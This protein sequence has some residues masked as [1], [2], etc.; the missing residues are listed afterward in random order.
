LTPDCPDVHPERE[1]AL[2]VRLLIAIC[3]GY[4]VAQLAL[5]P[6]HRPP[7]WDE[8]IYLSQVTPGVKAVFFMAHRAR[9]ITLLV[10]PVTWLGGSVAAVRLYLVVVSTL[11][12]A[13]VFWL[14][15]P[16]V[17]MAV[18]IAAFSF[19]FS[20][21]ALLSGSEVMPNFWA[22]ILGLGVAG[23]MARRFQGGRMRSVVFAA[24][25]LG[26]VALFRPT[27]SAVITA[28]VGAFVLIRRRASWRDLA[29][30]GVGLILGW[31]PWL[32]EMSIR[33]GGPLSAFREAGSTHVGGASLAQHVHAHLAFTTGGSPSSPIPLAGLA[34][35]GVLV[36]MAIVAVARGRNPSDRIA[37]LLCFI[38]AVALAVEYLAFVHPV[39]PRFLLP[40]YA[41][42]SIPL[43]VGTMS[44]L[45]DRIALRA[46]GSVVLV[47]LLPWAV[48]QGA[49]GER[50][51]VPKTNALAAFQDVGSTLRR[52]AAGRPCSFISAHWYPELQLASGCVGSSLRRSSGPSTAQLSQLEGRGGVVFVVMSKQA[53]ASSPL[54]SLAPTR[55][56]ARP[57]FV[58]EIPE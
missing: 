48:W 20:W 22:A 7:G 51:Q 31:L 56:G 45:R 30:L 3:L 11:A 43:G 36:A 53:P 4:A 33:F 40:T 41:F 24:A 25:L 23:F 26:G 15:I 47:L 29:V 12:V 1:R 35:W 16:V 28:S 49:A 55:A 52:L 14:W 42:A 21:F 5:F 27:E 34:W 44:L 13:A 39:T 37:G 54:G 50:F 2:A 57:W 9:G 17:G 10:A 19:A 6:I 38:G 46:L 18:P 8:S 58:Y 32:I